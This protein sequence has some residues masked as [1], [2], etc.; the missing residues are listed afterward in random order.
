MIRKHPLAPL[1]PALLLLVLA[2]PVRAQT[3]APCAVG[4]PDCCQ[5]D[6]DCDDGDACNGKETCDTETRT[7]VAGTVVTC[8]AQDVCHD[9]GT[10]DPATGICSNPAARDGTFCDDANACTQTD[11]CQN[12]IC[13]GADPVTCTAQDQC[14]DVGTCD[15]AT[16][17][18]SNPVAPDNAPC[19]DGI[20]CNGADACTNGSCTTHAGD[21]C[22][23]GAECKTTCDEATGS[24]S[25]PA[26][27]ACTDDGNVCTLDMCDGS[28]TCTHPAGHAGTVCRAAAGP[29]DV[30]ETC[31]GTSTAC[32]ANAF[33]P[34][35]RVC[36]AAAGPCDAAENCTGSAAACPTDAFL[37]AS[38]ICRPA[39]GI[40]DVAE[41]CPGN[42]P[43]CPADAQ[44]PDNTPCN[45]GVFCNGADVCASGSCVGH[46][47]DPCVG[48]AECARTCDEAKDTCFDPAGTAC[49][50]DGNVCTLD[51]CDGSGTCAH[52]A[53]NAGTVC[54]A[55]AGQCDVAE[56]CT[57][58]SATCPIDGFAPTSTV[59]R[60][61]AGTC[62]AAENCPGTSAACPANA[63][64]PATRVCRAAAG[65]CDVAESCTGSSAACPANAF[66][67]ATLVC[68]P[69]A[70][71]CDVAETC[72][73]SAAACPTDIFVT[74]GT[75]CRSATGTCDA[76][77]R[78]PGNGP[79]CP[80]DYPQQDG[81]PCSD[82][83][84]CT[85]T[86]T[87]QSGR[88]VGAGHVACTSLDQCHA[89]GLCDPTT[90][91]CSNPPLSGTT[92]DDGN[93]CTTDDHCV[94]GE[95]RGEPVSCDDTVACTTDRC[96]DGACEHVP[97]DARCD[98][99]E[100]VLAVCSPDDPDAD[101][102]GCV[103]TPVT[104]GDT[105]TD[106][107][108]ACTS[109]V[110]TT[111]RCTHP[112]VDARCLPADECDAGVCNPNADG[113][114]ASGCVRVPQLANGRAC[115]EDG[116]PCTNDVCR[117][118][119][120]A[121]EAVASRLTCDP[122]RP[123]YDRA[124]TL[125]GRARGLRGTVT[126]LLAAGTPGL[127]DGATLTGTLD[128]L[129]A[130]LDA[131]AATLGGRTSAAAASR[132]AAGARAVAVSLTPSQE[133]ARIAFVQVRSTPASVRG[134]LAELGTA[135]VRAGLAPAIRS[136]LR[137]R[138]RDL[139]RGTISLKRE[140]QRLKRS[141]GSLARP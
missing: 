87:C 115:V 120:C 11:T 117:E 29:C 34:V 47:G 35:S 20:F 41:R 4:Q 136:D 76:A 66:A 9:A 26:G 83:D 100:C 28:G 25:D 106:D 95:C 39:T 56:T 101:A 14:H 65:P 70:G 132:R 2:A 113:H 88:C 19:S 128:D 114:E 27:T 51:A 85:Q 38:T 52:P 122:V 82:A 103:A 96:V 97:T 3:A 62:D 84:A 60:A 140:L 133:R 72:T 37:A 78:C 55:T 92:C 112:A 118:G 134:F 110:C 139:L 57:G 18:C 130:A 73:G 71:D 46:A 109:D 36:R 91:L 126:E 104:E 129:A 137:R 42:G 124:R 67:P 15:P 93:A 45:D 64:Y 86:D 77:E 69:V 68:R 98:R 116:D 23:A 58:T 30:A 138:G 24:C 33:S 125:A 75:I 22:V 102:D 7:C 107:G 90:G 141:Q 54:R 135:Q 79:T 53:G 44:Q 40:C 89:V 13:T 16:G 61:A 94:T 59:C 131:A 48:G 80:A 31:T 1:V 8:V 21:P 119:A 99:G 81:T 74:A 49:T 105:C 127:P 5:A 43:T 121:H 50:D 111:G 17:V 123:A 10:C 32:P 108:F 63:F 12:G 6:V